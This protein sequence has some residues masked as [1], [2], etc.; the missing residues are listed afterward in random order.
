VSTLSPGVGQR[1]HRHG[2]ML[3]A[4]RW[5]ER[6]KAK[7]RQVL[8][9][10][11]TALAAARRYL[12]HARRCRAA[13]PTRRSTACKR[14]FTRQFEIRPGAERRL[15]LGAAGDLPGRRAERPGGGEPEGQRMTHLSFRKVVLITIL[16]LTFTPTSGSTAVR[17]G[18]FQAGGSSH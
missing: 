10:L 16:I 17:P 11:L 9:P 12:R 3:G 4:W 14:R 1:Q 13:T 6:E 7:P 15:K 18:S 2:L 8:L 5:S